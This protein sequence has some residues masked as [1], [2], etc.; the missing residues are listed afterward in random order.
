MCST[1]TLRVWLVNFN[2]N[3][4]S[5]VAVDWKATRVAGSSVKVTLC[6]PAGSRTFSGMF[7]PPPTS[8]K[9]IVI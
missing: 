4:E 1:L 5:F 6:A 7:T 9:I 8:P 2:F 3:N